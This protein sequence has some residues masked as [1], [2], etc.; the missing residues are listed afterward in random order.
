MAESYTSYSN[1]VKALTGI[2]LSAIRKG[3][4]QN[5]CYY[6]IRCVFRRGEVVVARDCT[7]DGFTRYEDVALPDRRGV[8]ILPAD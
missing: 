3:E 8:D 1:R 5:G 2:E 4:W 7:G 6:D